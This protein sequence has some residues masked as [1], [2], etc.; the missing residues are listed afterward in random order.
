MKKLN[1]VQAAIIALIFGGF[2]AIMPL[3]G[4]LIVF[5]FKDS[6]PFQNVIINNAYLVAFILLVILGTKMLRDVI[7]NK[8]QQEI[9]K[10]TDSSKTNQDKLS[11]PE[12]IALGVATSIDALMVGF[13][14]SVMDVNIVISVIV[15]GCT[16]FVF[17]FVGAFIGHFFGSR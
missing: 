1:F 14:F 15:I 16:T 11:I 13:A 9:D 10:L 4:F 17:S 6:E 12:L 7:K 3:I 8:R 2:Q 5:L